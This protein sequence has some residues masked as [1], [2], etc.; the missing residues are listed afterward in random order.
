MSLRFLLDT[1]ICIY[2]R[3]KKSPQIL[4]R[5]DEVQAGEAAM[6]TITHGELLYGAERSQNR[7]SARRILSELVTWIPVLSL[8]DEAADEYGK[9]RANLEARGVMIGTNDLWIGAHAKVAGLTLVTNN[10]KEFRRISCLKVE[11]WA[12]KK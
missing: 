9:V 2:I 3:Q 1:N 8:P 4:A 11:N 10:E 12:S 5:F 6:S 7:E